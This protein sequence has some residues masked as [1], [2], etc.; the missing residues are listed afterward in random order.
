M[1]HLFSRQ[2]AQ[3]IPVFT[4]ADNATTRR[5]AALIADRLYRARMSGIFASEETL[6][7]EMAEM[8]LAKNEKNRTI[9][10]ANLRSIKADILEGRWVLNGEP[11][12]VADTG[13]LND[14]Q[15]RCMAVV[16][17]GRPI[18]TMMMWGVD[19]D[20]RT[21]TD[22]GVA[23]TT[24]DYLSMAGGANSH[25]TAAVAGY[26]WQYQMRGSIS[27][28]PIYRPTKAQ[29]MDAVAQ[30]PL[31]A[32]SIAA[33]PRKGA[34][35]VGGISVLTFAHYI[36]ST[37]DREDATRFI[38]MIVRGGD[39][40]ADDPVFRARERLIDERARRAT[41]QTKAEILFRAWNMHRRGAKAQKIQCNGTLPRLER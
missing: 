9:K 14:G 37:I 13:E 32:E 26:V 15:H 18:K 24:A 17:T 21:T 3:P 10:T 35:R 19:R 36:L 5:A 38:Q 12:I 20:S 25:V 33:V 16:E 39:M 27:A 8:L 40:A 41:P 30:H 11:I 23:R 2:D 28:Q 22:Q 34:G 4:A 7:P 1:P 6:T 29:V 31:I